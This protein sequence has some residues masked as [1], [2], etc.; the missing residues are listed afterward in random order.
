MGDGGVP[1]VQIPTTSVDG[2]YIIYGPPETINTTVTYGGNSYT[3]TTVSNASV[4]QGSM[5]FT[6]VSDSNYTLGFNLTGADG[7]TGYLN[8][9][10]PKALMSINTGDQWTVKVNGTQVT[11][12]VASDATHWYLYFTTSL[13]TKPVTIIGTIPEFTLLIIPLLMIVTLIAV[14]L[15]RRRQ[16]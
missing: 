2:H 3:V 9:T 11:P 8:V 1:A 10:I 7:S 12:T 5:G 16:T 14:G 4:V 6:K 15:R 13:S